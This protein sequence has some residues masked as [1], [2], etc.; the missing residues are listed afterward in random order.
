V[1]TVNPIMN[2]PV[3][4]NDLLAACDQLHAR[5]TKIWAVLTFIGIGALWYVVFAYRCGALHA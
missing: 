2:R 1:L 4:D 3:V 5:M